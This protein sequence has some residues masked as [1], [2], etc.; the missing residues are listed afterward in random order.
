MC[1][2]L[3][4]VLNSRSKRNGVGFGGIHLLGVEVRFVAISLPLGSIEE[5][6]GR[7]GEG[8]AP[9]AP[10]V[11]VPR[12]VARGLAD[13]RQVRMR[14]LASFTHG[15]PNPMRISEPC[16]HHITFLV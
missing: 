15:A 16:E 9:V 11:P 1:W 2:V 10:S 5:D 12:P 7:T 6:H 8:G 13:R 3:I 4:S 14:L